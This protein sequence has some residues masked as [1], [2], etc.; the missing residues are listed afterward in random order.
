MH[1]LITYTQWTGR[2]H[3]TVN[4]PIKNMHPADWLI[5]TLKAQ[6][7][8]QTVLLFATEISAVQFGELNERL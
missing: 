3:K 7:E 8:A 2:A 1:W 5:Y 6:P 4:L